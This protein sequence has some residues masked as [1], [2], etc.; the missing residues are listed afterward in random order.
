MK[1]LLATVAVLACGIPAFSQGNITCGNDF[2]SAVFR[3]PIFG[4]VPANPLLSIVG[5]GSG[6]SPL[7][8]TQILFNPTGATSYADAPLLSGTN[9]TLALF[10]GPTNVTDPSLLAAIG[11]FSF[12]TGAP[13]G[14]VFFQTLTIT[15]VPPGQPA[16]V[17]ARAWDNRN[18]TLTNWPDAYTAWL[19]GRTAAGTGQMVLTAPLGGVD[20]NGQPFIP[21]NSTG[22]TSFN[23]YYAA[24][25]PPPPYLLAGPITNSANGHWYYL[26][27]PT[28]WP[29][30]E[31][32][33][34]SLGGH[35]ATIN[36]AAENNWVFTNFSTFGGVERTLWLGFNDAGQENIWFWVGGAPATYI[37][38]APGEP[39]NGG[40]F[41]PDEDQALM[42][43]PSSGYPLGSW[44]DAPD[45]QLYS[46]VVE[47]SAPEP[48]VLNGHWY[49]LLNYTNWPGAEQIAV[50]LGGHLA[51]INDAAENNWIFTNFSA[52][53]GIE[54]TLWIGLNDSASEGTWVWVS[55]QPV[56]FLNWSP[57]E[58]NS[59][60]G[61]FPDEDHAIIWHPSSGFPPG[62]W[63]DAPSNQMQ[64][65][66]VEV[67]GPPVLAPV[68]TSQPTN[69]TV[70]VGGS[71]TFRVTATG[72]APLAYQWRFN[73]TNLAGRPTSTLTVTAVQ[74]SQAGPYSVIVTNA[75]GSITSS[76]AIL[77]VNPLPPCANVFSNLVSWWRAENDTTDNWDSNNG[78]TS[79]KFA[80]GKIGQAFSF[81]QI[82]VA[83]SPSLH[84][85]D[86]LTIELWVKPAT[87]STPLATLVSKFDA[88]QFT[89]NPT[90]SSFYLGLYYGH[91]LFQV[92]TNGSP[93]RQGEITA[94][95]A[96]PTNQWSHIAATYNG[97]TLRLFVNGQFAGEDRGHPGRIFDGNS[98]L[99]IGAS[100]VSGQ[101]VQSLSGLLDEVS[102]YNRALPQ[103]E[104]QAIY[105]SDITGKCLQPPMILVQPQEQT[106]P[107]GE[108]VKFTVTV[109]GNKPLKYQW[110]FNGNIL[111]AGATNSALVLEKV[112]T[113]RAGLYIAAITNAV[114]FTFSARP[115]LKVLLPAPT[116]T[117]PPAGLISW[118]PGDGLGADAMSTNNI[119]TLTSVSFVTGKVDRA[120][121]FNGVTSFA[122]AQS[123]PSLNFGSN[124]D[125]SIEAWIKAGASNTA[126]PNVPILEKRSSLSGVTGV[127]YSLSLY[128]GRLAFWLATPTSNSQ[129][130]TN[131]SVFISGGPDLR[132]AMFHHV[133]VTLTRGDTNGGK[134]YVDGQVALTFDPTPRRASLSNA[135]PEW[136]LVKGMCR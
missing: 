90:N 42:W 46:A 134:L 65:A 47:V 115:E 43:H 12:R 18:G 19:G 6:F 78:S 62:S 23:I 124:T 54:R 135:S 132:D 40:G 101:F 39:N 4:P 92:S 87:T 112:T 69:L 103:T 100:L 122:Q 72:D 98:P 27:G 118:W 117:P 119:T 108:D 5:Q 11:Y 93:L 8:P 109:V 96:L 68:I 107:L 133:A 24:S 58:P 9:Y 59:G 31:Q 128:Q 41:F 15:N 84:F 66:V 126:N 52:F 63:N 36:N 120:F 38:W 22:W 20:F 110:Y 75:G 45:Y 60:G 82:T 7:A 14:F 81:P 111:I 71:A 32:I 80:A 61:V 97:Q 26:L 44:A 50:S 51:T 30:A 127:G 106:V 64:Y 86:A 2:G 85:S 76:P 21:P 74:F 37:N 25:N 136:R 35:L 94:T 114:G 73:G 131:A 28:N 123:S 17:Q 121:S 116:C 79:A 125:F 83:D 95:Q 113:N 77:T 48:I 130:T 91:P 70:Y 3:A 89:P 88:A 10:A 16:K 102:L 13:S 67:A 99:S 33:A 1:K 57:I 105:N 55:G 129:S 104:I 49:Y 53:G 34:V 29:A 56:T